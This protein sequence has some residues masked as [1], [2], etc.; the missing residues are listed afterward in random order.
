MVHVVHGGGQDAG[1]VCEG[2][3][4]VAPGGKHL[5]ADQGV[6]LQAAQQNAPGGGGRCVCV[7]ACLAEP[8]SCLRLVDWWANPFPNTVMNLKKMC[9]ADSDDTALALVRASTGRVLL[10]LG[11]SKG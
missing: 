4:H 3:V 6:H 5:A 10:C 7:A 2:G 11:L 1:Q 9:M 8:A